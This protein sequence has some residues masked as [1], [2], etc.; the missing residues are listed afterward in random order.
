MIAA[1]KHFEWNNLTRSV[2]LALIAM[3]HPNLNL[4]GIAAANADALSRGKK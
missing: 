1:D 2:R 3:A 4:R